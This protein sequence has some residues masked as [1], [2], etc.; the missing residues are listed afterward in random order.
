MIIFGSF[1]ALCAILQNADS[2]TTVFNINSPVQYG[3]HI[4][5][6]FPRLIPQEIVPGEYSYDQYLANYILNTNL[7]F[8]YMMNILY[9][10]YIGQDVYVLINTEWWSM[11]Y[12]ESLIKFIQ[13]RYGCEVNL[14]N[15]TSDLETCKETS[16]SI[17]GR[18]QFQAD[19]ERFVYTNF[20]GIMA[21]EDISDED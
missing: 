14:I 4:M 6:I 13:A 8:Y 5:D 15:E 10:D 16:F 19:K 17:E 7:A 9:S 2:K 20:D 21:A 18:Q 12:I 11:I 1:E 3:Y